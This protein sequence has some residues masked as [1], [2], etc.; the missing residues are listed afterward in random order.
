MMNVSV[1]FLQVQYAIFYT[2]YGNIF[3]SLFVERDFITCIYRD[4]DDELHIDGVSLG[5]SK[6]FD[7]II[8][9]LTTQLKHVLEANLQT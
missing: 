3:I 6:A 2:I 7:I 8:I 5:F 4:V 9:N 1:K